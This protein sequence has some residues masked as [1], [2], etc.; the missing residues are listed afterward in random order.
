MKYPV[1]EQSGTI[2]QN[3]VEPETDE[4]GEPTAGPVTEAEAEP[5]ADTDTNTTDDADMDTKT[6]D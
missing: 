2:T 6:T 4:K 5:G 3:V 1:F